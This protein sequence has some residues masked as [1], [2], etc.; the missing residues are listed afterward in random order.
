MAEGTLNKIGTNI[1]LPVSVANGG[2]GANNTS[3]A[4]DNLGLAIGS[5]VQAYD[6]DLQAIAALSGNGVSNRTGENTWEQVPYEESTYNPVI[7][8]S[9]T[10]PTVTY[11]TQYGLYTRIGNL[12]TVN[13]YLDILTIAGGSGNCLISLPIACRNNGIPSVS[14]MS[15][16]G[17]NIPT[18]KYVVGS[19]I[20]NTSTLQLLTIVDLL[21]NNNVLISDLAVSNVIN[22]TLS[23]W[24]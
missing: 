5:D 17:V 1:S 3:D 20:T 8:G 9:T 22:L 6:G 18:G 24:V 19:T 15:S 10:N 4:R 13:I 2:T 7:T 16:S 14:I 11:T 12:V 23:Y 21:G